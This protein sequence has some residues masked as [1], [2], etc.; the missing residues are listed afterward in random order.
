MVHPAVLL[1]SWAGFAFALQRVPL[2]VALGSAAVC[3]ALAIA[4]A[5][6]RSLNLI[7]RSRWLLLS[8]ALLFL[9]LTPGEYLPGLLGKLGVT[10]E[11]LLRCGEQL[12]RLLAL[13]TSLALLHEYIGK[14]GLLAGFHWLLGP[15]AWREK[16]VV[17]LMLVLDYVEHQGGIGWR[18]WIEP[19]VDKTDQVETMALVMPMLRGGDLAMIGV[20]LLALLVWIF[21]T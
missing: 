16:S 15:F 4:L 5:R 21:L 9:L 19:Q 14:H 18:E 12:S 1:V 3:S 8:L 20:I 10:H 13:L 7:R 17:R 11:G 6:Q 2:V